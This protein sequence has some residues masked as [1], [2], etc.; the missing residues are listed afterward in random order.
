ML[1][2]FQVKLISKLTITLLFILMVG[3]TS[4]DIKSQATQENVLVKCPETLPYSYSKTGSGW[5]LMS[6]EWSEQYHECAIRHNGLVDII[7]NSE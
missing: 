5:L 1:R 7:E 4:V 2:G 3:C 6:K